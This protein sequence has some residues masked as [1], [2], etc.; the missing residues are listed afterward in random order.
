MRLQ[1]VRFVPAAPTGTRPRQASRAIA[2]PTAAALHSSRTGNGRSRA[3]TAPSSSLAQQ[4]DSG[5]SV[6]FNSR[7]TEGGGVRAGDH[8]VHHGAECRHP[9][10]PCADQQ[11]RRNA[12][13]D[14]LGAR[15]RPSGTA[16]HADTSPNDAR[17]DARALIVVADQCVC[18]LCGS[19]RLRRL[20]HGLGKHRAQLRHRLRPPFTLHAQA[21]RSRAGTA[22]SSSLAQQWTAAPACRSTAAP[23]KAA[24]CGR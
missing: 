4:L 9:R 23:R 11:Q 5:S 14:E 16:G 21:R 10:R 8:L 13:G 22:P 17:H 18:R 2:P 6:S 3:G 1:V 20:G 7:A 19:C 24:A 15:P 12:G